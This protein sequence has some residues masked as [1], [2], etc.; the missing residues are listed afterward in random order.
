MDIGT[1]RSQLHLGAG[2]LEH[3]IVEEPNV[4]TEGWIWIDTN[5]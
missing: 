5:C 3:G 2:I 1:Q 4:S